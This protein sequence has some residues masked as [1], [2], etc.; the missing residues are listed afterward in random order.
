MRHSQLESDIRVDARLE[1]FANICS[2]PAGVLDLE[3]E[4]LDDLED[5]DAAGALV[6]EEGKECD[7][8]GDW[9]RQVAE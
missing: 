1:V 4:V 6:G 9:C 2:G 5:D 3:L 8:H 7:R